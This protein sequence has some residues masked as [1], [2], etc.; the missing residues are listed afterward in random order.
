MAEVVDLTDMLTRASKGKKSVDHGCSRMLV[1]I[2]GC[3][4]GRAAVGLGQRI[5][6]ALGCT[7]SKRA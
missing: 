6:H 2:G 7:N 3:W 1:D 4:W 5:R